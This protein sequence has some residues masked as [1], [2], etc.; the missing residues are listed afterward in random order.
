MKFEIK[1]KIFKQKKKKGKNLIKNEKFFGDDYLKDNLKVSL[2]C[3]AIT[4]VKELVD[5]IGYVEPTIALS[6]EEM[7]FVCESVLFKVSWLRF[8]DWVNYILEKILTQIFIF[9][10]F[11]AEYL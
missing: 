8:K 10:L 3:T 1:N 5:C 6:V 4:G 7:N 9:I 11:I 2:I